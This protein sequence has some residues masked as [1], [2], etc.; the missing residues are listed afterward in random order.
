[1]SETYRRD[2]WEC[3]I[4]LKQ[5]RRPPDHKR[6]YNVLVCRKCRNG[7]ANRRQA[8]FL[9]DCVVF[10]LLVGG[11]AMLIG[12]LEDRSPESLE[13]LWAVVW[14]VLAVIIVPVAFA[15]KDSVNGRSPGKILFGLQVVDA[16]SRDPIGPGQSFKR[17]LILAVPYLGLLG[18]IVG[19]ITML[20]GRRWGEGWAGTEVVWLK[21]A[22]RE[23]FAPAGRYCR[24][25]G[26]DLTGN[27]SG[28]C[29]ECGTEIRDR[30]LVPQP[31]R[32]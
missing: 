1:M 7:F 26:Y 8:A 20:R 32:A 19:C 21:H 27:I 16:Y 10:Y 9:V 3:P 2:S 28:R 17:N 18:L 12:L 4:C 22:T 13:S 14:R 6:L 15:L 25:C 23:P 30:E 24:V 5:R 11:A 31:R 29:P